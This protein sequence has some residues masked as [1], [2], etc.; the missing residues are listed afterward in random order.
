MTCSTEYTHQKD[1]LFDQYPEDIEKFLTSLGEKKFRTKQVLNWI[2]EQKIFNPDLMSNVSKETRQAIKDNFDYEFPEIVSK[3]TAEDGATKLLLKTQKGQH[4]EAVILRYKN[5]VSLCVSSQVGCKLACSFCQTG[6]LG[7]FRNL[8]ASEIMSQFALANSIVKEEGKK[9]SH[10]VF[11]GMGEPLDNY[12]NVIRTVNLMLHEEAYSLNP[13]NVTISTSGIVPKIDRLA[14]DTKAA[15]AISLHAARDE[16]RTE[17][18]PINRRYD[19]ESLKKSLLNWQKTTGKKLTIEY[20]LIKDKTCSRREAKALVKFLHGFRAKINLIPFNSH[21]GMEYDRPLDEDIRE[22]Q[23]YLS[24]RSY[25][26]PVRYS[27]GM[28]VSGACGQLAAKQ[29]ENLSKVP[30]RKAVIGE[31]APT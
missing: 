4:V 31:Q 24:D 17:L 26:A 22:F 29:K 7:F 6:K 8:S 9:I 30:Y 3:L 18:M 2:F 12:D 15:L 25:P 20:I 11:M 1:S 27:K 13:K 10:V 5:R 19:L 23:K 28:E 21:P 14:E 16:L